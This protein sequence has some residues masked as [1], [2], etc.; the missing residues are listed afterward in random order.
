MSLIKVR[1]DRKRNWIDVKRGLPLKTL[2][3][4]LILV[5]LAIWYLSTRF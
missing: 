2:L 5:V 4:L 3:F 1:R